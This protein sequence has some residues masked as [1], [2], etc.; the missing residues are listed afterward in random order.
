MSRLQI[1]RL[2][3]SV[4]PELSGEVISV[5][6]D[7]AEGLALLKILGVPMDGS[8]IRIR[9]GFMCYLETAKTLFF[10][11]RKTDLPPGSV[12]RQS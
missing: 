11:T 9:T 2:T 7:T 4:F 3:A 5:R 10:A 6:I 1:S 12:E 8:P